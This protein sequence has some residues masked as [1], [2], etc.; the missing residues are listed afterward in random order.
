[1]NWLRQERKKVFEVE[2][3]VGRRKGSTEP[4]LEAVWVSYSAS[5]C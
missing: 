4:A 1:M 2:G 3:S 5:L